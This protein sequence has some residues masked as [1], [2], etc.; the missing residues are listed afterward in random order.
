MASPV[1]TPLRDRSLTEELSDSPT[2]SPEDAWLLSPH[3]LRNKRL[4]PAC[5][6]KPKGADERRATTPLVNNSPRAYASKAQLGEPRTP[7]QAVNRSAPGWYDVERSLKK[8]AA[9]PSRP[10]H[11]ARAD[12][13]A[14]AGWRGAMAGYGVL[15]GHSSPPPAEAVQHTPPQQQPLRNPLPTVAHTRGLR[16]DLGLL[17]PPSTATTTETL[18]TPELLRVRAV[19][20]EASL[21]DQLAGAEVEAEV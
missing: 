9:L 18:A 5:I 1:V 13:V 19:A 14:E 8:R 21:V 16:H 20:A 4:T 10:D 2:S 3:D 11:K 12:V 15:P 17:T 6:P 7:L